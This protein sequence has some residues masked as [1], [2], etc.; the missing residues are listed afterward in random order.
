LVL[1][2][3][4]QV[5]LHHHP[6]ASPRDALR[7]WCAAQVALNEETWQGLLLLA[8]QASTKKPPTA[9]ANAALAAAEAPAVLP[10]RPLPGRFRSPPPL[11]SSP[12]VRLAE[13]AAGAPEW[14]RALSAAGPPPLGW[15]GPPHAKRGAGPRRPRPVGFA[16]AAPER[17][18][19]TVGVATVAT[20]A[21]GVAAR[22]LAPHAQVPS[23]SQ[24]HLDHHG[25]GLHPTGDGAHV[26]AL[27]AEYLGVPIGR[28][29]RNL[30]EALLVLEAPW[31]D[32]D[33]K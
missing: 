8:M 17:A 9:V 32:P 6:D 25:H 30:R 14:L 2:L 33:A 31:E 21:D 12:T 15:R 4:S 27:V 24:H 5:S 29:L 20:A 11:A 3:R 26:K 18:A 23:Q 28:E 10:P 1:G 7:V 16:L 22:P 19:A 13:P